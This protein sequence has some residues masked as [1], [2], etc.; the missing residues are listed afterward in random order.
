[1]DLDFFR[2]AYHLPPERLGACLEAFRE[3]TRAAKELAEIARDSSL[4]HEYPQIFCA[5]IDRL[6]SLPDPDQALS[7]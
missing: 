1:M 2:S 6:P 3:P 5:L 4:Q 7:L